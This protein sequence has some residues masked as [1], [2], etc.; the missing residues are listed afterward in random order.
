MFHTYLNPQEQHARLNKEKHAAQYKKAAKGKRQR[1]LIQMYKKMASNINLQ[2][3]NATSNRQTAAA[4]GT[5]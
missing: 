1:E 5:K 3:A 4:V 2:K